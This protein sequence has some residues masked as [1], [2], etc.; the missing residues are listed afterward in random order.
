L[1]YYLN[2]ANTWIAFAVILAVVLIIVFLLIIFLAKRV[3]L[4]IKLI[5]EASKAVIGIFIT[6]F[7]PILPF[8]L[9]IGLFIYFAGVAL[10]IA[11]IAT[12]EYKT[13]NGTNATKC[14]PTDFIFSRNLTDI[15]CI[16]AGLK[17]NEFFGKYQWLPQLYNL[18]VFFWTEAFVVGLNQMILA[19]INEIY[20]TLCI[21][22]LWTKI[23]KLRIK[24][25]SQFLCI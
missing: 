2:Y 5:Q 13:S 18:F 11:S 25:I 20:S 17:L 3:R 19:G 14:D 9:Q 10:Y 16:Y 1:Y 8:L 12:F 6:L 23:V 15:K 7:F 21:L 22:N 24:I 4:A